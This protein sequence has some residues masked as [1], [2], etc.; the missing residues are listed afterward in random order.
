[1]KDFV[2]NINNQFLNF[3]LKYDTTNDNIIRK[4]IHTF[5]VAD[6]CFL[7][8]CKLKLSENDR[9]LAYLCGILHDI[10]RF[11]QWKQ[12]NTYNDKI[13]I[14]HGELSYT[15]SNDF[16]LSMLKQ[17]DIETVRLA[18]KYHT[19]PYPGSDKR[20]IQFNTIILAADAYANVQNTANGAQRM[21]M[22]QDG[23]TKEILEAFKAQKPLWNFSPKTKLDRALMLSACLYYVHYDFLKKQ[24]LDFNLID[25]V[26]EN[27]LGY[28]NQEDQKIYED[29]IM[30]LKEN[31]I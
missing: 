16:N 20:V 25:I 10:G 19:K 7:I 29:A 13:S 2:Q 8:A 17:E 15:L 22:T 18:I 27:F 31:Y 9:D 14:D 11:E 12:Y 21:T 1:M 30:V 4:I 23:Y 6:A 5:T 26:K 3:V 28:L 24:I